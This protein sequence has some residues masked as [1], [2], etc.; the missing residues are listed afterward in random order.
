M[1]RNKV[2]LTSF[3]TPLLLMIAPVAN[4]QD[5]KPFSI[6]ISSA[7]ATME[8]GSDAKIQVVVTAAPGVK[9]SIGRGKAFDALKAGFQVHVYDTQNRHLRMTP[10][11]WSFSGKK[12]SADDKSDYGGKDY[13]QEFFFIDDEGAL[14]LEPG[15][16][17]TYSFDLFD[18]YSLSPGQIHDLR[19]DS[20]LE[21]SCPRQVLAV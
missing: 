18:A 16:D 11:A 10:M 3:I 12:A 20:R 9:T 6:K 17:R 14:A 1:I 8:A 2:A 4:A 21:H 5:S 7:Q 19:V 13:K 15:R